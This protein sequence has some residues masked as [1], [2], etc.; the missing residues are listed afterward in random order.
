MVEKGEAPNQNSNLE[1][2]RKDIEKFLEDIHDKTK[3]LIAIEWQRIK[4]AK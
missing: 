2:L 4:R 3:E 1:K